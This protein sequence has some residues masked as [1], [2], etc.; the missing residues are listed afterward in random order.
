[1]AIE[2]DPAIFGRRWPM[3]LKVEKGE[4][5]AVAVSGEVDAGLSKTRVSYQMPRAVALNL[6][7]ALGDVL[8]DRR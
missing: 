6:Y 4:G 3:V 8:M 1:M 7:E 2:I 5:G